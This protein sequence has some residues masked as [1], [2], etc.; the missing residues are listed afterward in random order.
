MYSGCL[1]LLLS[2]KRVQTELLFGSFSGFLNRL[3]LGVRA[4]ASGVRRATSS[5]PDLLKRLGNVSLAFE[6]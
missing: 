2:K 3:A 4:N 6:L 5:K 1:M